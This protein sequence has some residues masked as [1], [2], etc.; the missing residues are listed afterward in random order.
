MSELIALR[1]N[2]M[3]HKW[4]PWMFVFHVTS[5]THVNLPFSFPFLFLRAVT[6]YASFKICIFNPLFCQALG[7]LG[8]EATNRYNLMTISHLEL[9]QQQQG[10]VENFSMTLQHKKKI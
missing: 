1:L 4:L 10:D 5:S 8:T 6:S 2:S 7:T 9:Q 3:T